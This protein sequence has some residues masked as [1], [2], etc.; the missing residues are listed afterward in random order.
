VQQQK[1]AQLLHHLDMAPSCAAGCALAG[2]EANRRVYGKT[3]SP[4]DILGGRVPPPSAFAFKGFSQLVDDLHDVEA[5]SRGTEPPAEK[6]PAH[7]ALSRE[8]S[9]RRVFPAYT[10]PRGFYRF[11]SSVGSNRGSRQE[12]G[13]QEHLADS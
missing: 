11:G 4:G 7:D 1:R 6:P 10:S 2:H 3:V 13:S 12:L 8:S 9:T 5:F